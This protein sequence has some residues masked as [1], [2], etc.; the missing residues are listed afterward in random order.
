MI[1][2]VTTRELLHQVRQLAQRTRAELVQAHLLPEDLRGIAR[3]Y[4]L[5]LGWGDLPPTQ[6][7]CYLAAEQRILLNPRGQ[8]R[9][10]R[11]FTFYHELLHHRIEHDDE[12]LSL[13]ADATPPADE[14]LMERL[15]NV[16]AAEMLLP[17]EEVQRTV[18]QHGLSPSTIPVLCD[19]Y[20]ASSIAVALQMVHT[21]T[22]PV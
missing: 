13:F 20:Q 3:H 12:I 5:T 18:Q 2:P 11:H 17:G 4:G 1:I 16:G 7:G 9:V 8:G 19:R 14:A 21:A 6:L 10:R 15:C 22:H